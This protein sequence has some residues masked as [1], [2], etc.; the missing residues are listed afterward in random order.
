MVAHHIH[1][2][3]KESQNSSEKKA[4]YKCVKDM[5]TILLNKIYKCQAHVVMF[6]ITSH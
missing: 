2:I 4:D 6:N 1:G 3:C 5:Y